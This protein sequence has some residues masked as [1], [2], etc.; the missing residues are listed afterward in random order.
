MNYVL[1]ENNNRKEAYDKEEVLALL[2][3]AIQDGT[4]ANVVADAAFISKLKCCVTG[5]TN[6]VAFIPEAKY[7][8]MLAN[9]TLKEDTLYIITDDQ[10]GD[11]IERVINELVEAV[12]GLIEVGNKYPRRIYEYTGTW[13]GGRGAEIVDVTDYVE[14][15]KG[16]FK[17][18]FKLQG[19]FYALDLPA[20]NGSYNVVTYNGETKGILEVFGTEVRV[21]TKEDFGIFA[22]DYYEVL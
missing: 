20:L 2:N 6:N 13:F 18:T 15:Q 5:G 3:K 8:E 21:E 4:L 12:N 22:V 19:N 11:N 1:D 14:N 7:N 10:T 16:F 9:K 17:V